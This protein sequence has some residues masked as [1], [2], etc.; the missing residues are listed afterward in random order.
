MSTQNFILFRELIKV[1]LNQADRL[2]SIPSSKEWQILY[3]L[4]EKQSLVGICFNGVQT[5]YEKCPEQIVQLNK[6]LKIRWFG[7][8]IRIQKR[9]EVFNKR[10]VELQETLRKAGFNTYIMKGQGNAALYPK[11]LRQLRLPGDIDIYM[12]GGYKKIVEYVNSTFPTDEVNELEIQYHCFDDVAVEIHYRPFILRNPIKNLKLQAFFTNE[13]NKCFENR[14]IL[15]NIGAITI[16]TLTFNLV[17]QMVHIYHHMI[18]GGIGMRQLMDYYYLLIAARTSNTEF[19]I[20]R[21]VIHNIGLDRFASSLMWVLQTLFNGDETIE[22]QVS[23]RESDIYKSTFW[24]WSPNAKNGK[25]VLNEVLRTGNFGHMDENKGDM[26][27]KLKN[28]LYVNSEAI[29]MIRFE[30]MA[31]FWTPLWRIYHF[32]GVK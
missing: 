15:Q 1:S 11:K 14:M 30:S 9:N 6:D 28:F 23:R 16:P 13:Q 8:A 12:D 7:E 32:F 22:Y 4:S 10:C 31:W 5:L 18:T 2:S 20:V 17:H 26:T 27:N 24:P 29:R 25:F 21:S 3:R 19:Q